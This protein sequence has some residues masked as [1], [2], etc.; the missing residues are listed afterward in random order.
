MNTV[1]IKSV[2]LI[3]LIKKYKINIINI[4]TCKINS[5]IK[6]KCIINFANIKTCDIN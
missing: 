3:L 1:Y 5:I 2:K 4:K 6:E